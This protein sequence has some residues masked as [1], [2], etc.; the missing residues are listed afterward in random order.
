MRDEQ[1]LKMFGCTEL[2]LKSMFETPLSFHDPRTMVVS[3]LSD[4]QE[5]LEV[6]AGS[7]PPGSDTAQRLEL[8]RQ[9]TNRAKWGMFEYLQKKEVKP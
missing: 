4:V 3:I 5:L 2:V 9:F 1:A 7:V 6:V 8:A